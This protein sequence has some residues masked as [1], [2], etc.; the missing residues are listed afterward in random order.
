MLLVKNIEVELVPED[1]IQ[2]IQRDERNKYLDYKQI[3]EKVQT[4]VELIR[5]QRFVNER[6]E[7]VCIGMSE[8][9]RTAIGLPF[10]V[11]NN[12][13]QELETLERMYNFKTKT[14]LELQNTIA[15]A[16]FLGRLRYLF[17]CKLLHKK[18]KDK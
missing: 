6:G 4:V 7:Q 11:Y 16:K 5:G 9:V 13:K 15:M 14:L 8:K 12:L 3:D 10:E 2:I 1:I 18:T 17:T